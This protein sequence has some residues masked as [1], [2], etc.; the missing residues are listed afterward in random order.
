MAK[1]KVITIRKRVEDIVRSYKIPEDKQS[2]AIVTIM[3]LIERAKSPE[4]FCPKCDTRMSIELE[5]GVLDC[6]S[7]GFKKKITV[8]ANNAP[9]PS[10]IPADNKSVPPIARLRQKTESKPNEAEPNS[11]LLDAIDK[12]EQPSKTITPK[13]GKSILDMAN[14]RGGGSAVT[15]EDEKEIEKNVPGAKAG[16]INWS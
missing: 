12:A 16:G 2:K 9:A 3:E 7:C 8:L 11:A 15:E 10:V 4:M 14:S 6:F 5:T 1:K 13:N